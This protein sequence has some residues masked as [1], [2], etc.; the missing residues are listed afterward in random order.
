MEVEL[1]ADVVD[2]DAIAVDVAEDVEAR[3]VARNV[4]PVV[5]YNDVGCALD[6]IEV[7]D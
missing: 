2:S 1:T 5:V 4:A 6:V 3:V 7:I